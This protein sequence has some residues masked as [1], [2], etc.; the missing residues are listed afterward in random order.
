MWVSTA[1][2]LLAVESGFD[3]ARW[4]EVLRAMAKRWAGSRP[5]LPTDVPQF[6]APLYVGA[7]LDPSIEEDGDTTRPARRVTRQRSA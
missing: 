6:A 7:R 2:E 5:V 1:P 3:R 4:T